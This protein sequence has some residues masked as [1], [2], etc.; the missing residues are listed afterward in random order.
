MNLEPE[1]AF[2]IELIRRLDENIT[3]LR[4]QIRYLKIIVYVVSFIAVLA[5]YAGIAATVASSKASD[6]SEAATALTVER[7]KALVADR[8]SI[9]AQYNVQRSEVRAALKLSLRTLAGDPNDLNEREKQLADA[10][11]ASVDDA[12]PF[13]DCSAP[14]ITS[15]YR[16]PPPDPNGA[17]AITTTTGAIPTTTR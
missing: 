12:L 4:D 5:I 1:R 13:R 9:C 6:A 16:D 7:D 11:D 15:Y 2:D 10:Y 8:F 14:G 17:G 3:A